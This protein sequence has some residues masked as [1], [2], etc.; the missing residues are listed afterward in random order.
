M[1]R[2]KTILKNN[3]VIFG[4]GLSLVI[5]GEW[6]PMREFKPWSNIE[7]Q[8]NIVQSLGVVF[9]LLPV[10]IWYVQRKKK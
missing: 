6:L 8:T 2:F 4:V 1:R 5:G 7:L 10:L 9:S 3:W